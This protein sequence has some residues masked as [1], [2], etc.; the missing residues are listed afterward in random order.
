MFSQF[1]IQVT[2]PLAADSAKVAEAA[3]ALSPEAILEKAPSNISEFKSL[4]WADIFHGMVSQVVT[5]CFH[6]PIALVV[7]YV[8]KFVINKLYSVFKVILQRR[9]VDLS[10]S[11]FLLSLLRITL[12]FILVVAVV[13]I[14]GIETS[15]FIALFASAGVAVG[16][17]LSGTLQN[18]AGGVLI[19]LLKPYKVGDYIEHDGLKGFVKE[20]QI[21]H[22]IITTYSND[23]IVI[24]NGGLS[25]GV[26]N[27]FSSEKY[28]RLEWKVSV[29][30]GADVDKARK[31]ILQILAD[32]QRL[33]TQ[34]EKVASCGVQPP[35]VAVD[36]LSSSD[37]VLVVRAWVATPDYWPAKYAIAEQLYKELPKHG[38]EFPFPQLDV[39]LK[40]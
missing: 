33:I 32:D 22:T 29:A 2:T 37:V 25:T 40:K 4:P 20:I 16:M 24:P 23:R 18:F 19:L 30:Y 1:L 10:L 26:V 3:A 12:M 21:F 8:G 11:S 14:L 35:A 17:A 39:N 27:N 28:H 5:F 38:L 6:L 7:F 13:G 15:S 36:E 31:V 9:N 34:P